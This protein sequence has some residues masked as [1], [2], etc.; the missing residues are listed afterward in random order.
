MGKDGWTRLGGKKGRK[1]AETIPQK[2]NHKA[3]SSRRT[4]RRAAPANIQTPGQETWELKR[5]Q[6]LEHPMIEK[7]GS[8][9]NYKRGHERA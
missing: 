3:S 9:R 6:L 4:P 8:L 1:T 5:N 2:E 7:R